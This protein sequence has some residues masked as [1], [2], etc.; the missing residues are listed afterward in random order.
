MSFRSAPQESPRDRRSYPEGIPV[1]RNRT[2]LTEEI[3]CP[4]ENKTVKLDKVMINGQNFSDF[5]REEIYVNLP[6]TGKNNG[7]R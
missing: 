3:P 5:N 7:Y 6:A 2:S 4:I 1:G